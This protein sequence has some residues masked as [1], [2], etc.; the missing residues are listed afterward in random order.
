[1]GHLPEDGISTPHPPFVLTPGLGLS[2][3][4]FVCLFFFPGHIVASLIALEL[5]N[6]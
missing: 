3:K 6:M 2:K 5:K 4:I 1:M